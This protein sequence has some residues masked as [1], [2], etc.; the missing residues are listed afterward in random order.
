MELGVQL[1]GMAIILGGG[2]LIHHLAGKH[3]DSF[4][5]NIAKSPS[6]NYSAT[7]NKSQSSMVSAKARFA[8][9]Q[10]SKDGRGKSKES[11]TSSKEER[12][13]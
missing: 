5:K 12:D 3:I 8:Y 11:P 13:V 10:N 7:P 6:V 2:Y 9:G 4:S 1:A